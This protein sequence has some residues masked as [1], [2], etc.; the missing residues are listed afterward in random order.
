[1]KYI[2]LYS[3]IFLG[4]V[5]CGMKVN[6]Q[7]P[8]MDLIP[9]QRQLPHPET[10]QDTTAACR[11]IQVVR[12][13]SDSFKLS[14]LPSDR[15][16]SGRQESGRTRIDLESLFKKRGRVTRNRPGPPAGVPLFYKYIHPLRMFI[17][18]TALK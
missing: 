17:Q 10:V 12:Q 14:I 6:A 8:V 16:E 18:I 5:L 2:V 7:K 4:I 13:D 9:V 1:M 3:S 15:V 11:E